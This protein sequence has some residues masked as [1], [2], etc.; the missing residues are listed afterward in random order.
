MLQVICVLVLDLAVVKFLCHPAWF[1]ITRSWRLLRQGQRT[2]APIIGYNQWEDADHYLQYAPIVKLTTPDGK[3]YIIE[4]NA[5]SNYPEDIGTLV[6]IYYDVQ[7]PSDAIFKPYS[8][9][10]LHLLIL[11]VV[12]GAMLG[13][14]IIFIHNLL[15]D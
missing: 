3:E 6:T 4:S 11:L 1:Q 8:V 10:G 9:I 2:K 12:L 7:Y 5:Y 14:N 13:I 15:V